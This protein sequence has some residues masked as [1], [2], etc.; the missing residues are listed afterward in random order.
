MFTDLETSLGGCNFKKDLKDSAECRLEVQK[1]YQ[2]TKLG[3]WIYKCQNTLEN[4]L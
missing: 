2:C 3:L 1:Y 4:T